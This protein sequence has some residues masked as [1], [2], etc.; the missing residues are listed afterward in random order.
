[1]PIS[2][3]YPAVNPTLNL[4]FVNSKTLDPRITFTRAATGTYYDGKTSAIAE[5]NLI[6]YSNFQSGTSGW[7][8][9]AALTTNSNTAVAPDGYTTAATLV[10]GTNA[11]N[12]SGIT[13]TTFPMNAG[14]SYTYSI[15]LKYSA[16]NPS[17][18]V[19]LTFYDGTSGASYGIVVDIQNGVWAANNPT[20]T[21]NGT[22][23]TPFS[24]GNGWYRYSIKATPSSNQ[25]NTVVS[26]AFSNIASPTSY[27]YGN[28]MFAA[29]GVSNF[30][31]WGAQVEAHSAAGAYQVTTSAVITNYIPVLQSA[32][33]NTARLDYDPVSGVAKGLLMEQQSTNLHTQ[34]GSIGLTTGNAWGTTGSSV[35]LNSNIA[36]DGSL[37][38]TLLTE[39]N[40][41]GY[42]VVY[43]ALGNYISFTNGTVY[44]T[45][46]YAKAGTRSILCIGSARG[47]NNF[48][49]YFNLATGQ[50]GTVTGT[51]QLSCSMTPVGNGWYRC[52]SSV[53]GD[54]AQ[55]QS[56]ISLC[57]ADNVSSYPGNG[58][59]NAYI[60][61]AQ[62][63]ALAFPTSY[64][65]TGA[66]QVTRAVE[67]AT[68]QG[69]NFTPLYNIG[70]GTFYIGYTPMAANSASFTTV[71]SAG[72]FTNGIYGDTS[73]RTFINSL[74]SNTFYTTATITTGTEQKMA[75]AYQSNNNAQYQNGSV[76]TSG[77]NGAISPIPVTGVSLAGA[78]GQDALAQTYIK[79]FA[80]YPA[81]LTNT[82]LQSLTGS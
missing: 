56:H 71:S 12:G 78:W 23:A 69:A 54:G 55:F 5:Q 41:T 14:V 19:A 65:P 46:V 80:Y 51:G 64:I 61:G 79:K 52:V 60:W 9:R 45:T 13:S 24:V 47:N 39:D 37:S 35:A 67:R 10:Q 15:Y 81:R 25:T 22:Y 6:T 7:G 4:D 20:N 74:G 1:M 38:A 44:T 32:P 28:P 27:F 68:I 40:S 48:G 75:I 2:T 17:Q 33:A 59:G 26:V 72:A 57:S 36:P 16:S 18:Y 21:L 76:L 43:G 53:T 82:Q 58:S 3:I 8:Q 30:Y 77:T 62:V 29:D 31:A 49:G 34:S 66:S 63:E 42:H 70:Q 11:T 73:G 50:V